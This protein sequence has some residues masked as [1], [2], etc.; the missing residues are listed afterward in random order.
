MTLANF[1]KLLWPHKGSEGDPSDNAPGKGRSDK[2]VKLLVLRYLVDKTDRYTIEFRPQADGS[3][4]L[5][6]INHPPDPWGKPVTVNHLY[7]TGEVCVTAGREPRTAERARA[8]AMF[9]TKGWSVYCRTGV[10]PNGR[11][12]VNVPDG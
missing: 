6:A 4:K 10:F 1:F 8:I 7:S 9:W 5:F 2:L 11:Q 3:I 12:R